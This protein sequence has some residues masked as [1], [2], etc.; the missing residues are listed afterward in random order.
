MFP[1]V[2]LLL[3]IW[4]D[5]IDSLAFREFPVLFKF[6]LL[7]FVP[8]FCLPRSDLAFTP[9]HTAGSFCVCMIIGGNIN[10]VLV[11]IQKK[12]SRE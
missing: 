8:L 5:T 11:W 7:T 6:N 3:I 2:T 1:L 10:K 9:K 4:S 12:I